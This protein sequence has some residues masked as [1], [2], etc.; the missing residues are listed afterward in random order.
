V[1]EN[2]PASNHDSQQTAIGSTPRS[3]EEISAA[4]RRLDAALASLH[5][6]LARR[7]GVSQPEL[8]AITH[9]SAAGELGPT[10]LARRLDVTTGAVTAL[11]DRLAE[12]GHL[13]RQPHPADR[14]R[15]ELHVTPHARDEV[16]RHILPL[17]ADIRALA[18]TFSAEER[19][20]IGRFLEELAA[21]VQ[22]HADSDLP[23]S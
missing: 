22:R 5:V 20:A 23:H 14:R 1:T 18:D 8:A 16:M 2:G 6:A 19:D 4:T 21:I 10:D 13:V 15:L 3:P 12:R 9:V 7:L 17:T 11:V